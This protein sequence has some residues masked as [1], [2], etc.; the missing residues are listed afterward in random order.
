MMPSKPDTSFAYRASQFVINNRHRI[1]CQCSRPDVC[2]ARNGNLKG[3]QFCDI[4]KGLVDNDMLES[5]KELEKHQ[6][7]QR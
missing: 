4:C 2:Y 7:S 5:L 6:A 1:Y 3:T